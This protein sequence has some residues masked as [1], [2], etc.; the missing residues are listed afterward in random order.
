MENNKIIQGLDYAIDFIEASISRLSIFCLMSG[1]ILGTIE[2][3]TPQ[4]QLS[5][6]TWYSLVWAIVQ[7]FALDGLFLGV[8]FLLRD[9]WG[10]FDIPARLWYG[11]IAFLLSVVAALVNCTL[12]YQELHQTA[13]V[14]DA[15]YQL[16]ISQVEF[17]YT[18]AILIVLVTALVCTLP[19][20]RIEDT[21]E[22]LDQTVEEVVNQAV[23]QEVSTMRVEL[24]EVKSLLY[25]ITMV[26]PSTIDGGMLVDGS[27]SGIKAIQPST[28]DRIKEYIAL[29]PGVKNKDIISELG[30]PEST[31]KTYASK[32]R[33]EL[34]TNMVEPSTD[35]L[36]AIN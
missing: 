2:I 33:R 16:G 29:N 23:S 7:A 10:R 21:T 19:R 13:S 4:V 17:S 12:A 34:S 20:K 3:F 18:R 22:K 9:N 35:P 24:M 8:L 28:Y 6:T 1:F 15:M 14:V 27:T 11:F 5:S 32:V 25:R 26:E 30:I 31:V 36:I